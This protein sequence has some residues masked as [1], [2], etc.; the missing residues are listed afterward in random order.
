MMQN[1]SETKTIVFRERDIEEK[2]IVN[3]EERENVGELA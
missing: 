2:L 1:I 3:E